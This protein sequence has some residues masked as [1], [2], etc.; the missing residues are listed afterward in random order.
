MSSR[1]PMNGLT[2][3]A[4]AFAAR[5]AWF[6]LK[7]SVVLIRTPSFD[8]TLIALRPSVVIWIFTTTFLW[9]FASCRPCLTISSASVDVTSRLI[10]PSTRARMSWITSPHFRPVFAT[11]VGF[12]VTPSRTPHHAPPPPPAR[13]APARGGPAG[14]GGGA[15][16]ARGGAP[17][18]P[19]ARLLGEY[20]EGQPAHP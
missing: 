18:G 6:A 5:I 8:R 11:R 4:P 15:A 19:G 16:A 13:G 17:R 2:Y 1:R 12:V 7:M 20:R 14:G 9:S 3:F 10:G